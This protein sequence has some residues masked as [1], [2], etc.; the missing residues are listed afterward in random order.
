MALYKVVLIGQS[1]VG[2]SSTF[3]RFKTG[4][5]E[6]DLTSTIGLD[7]EI[8]KVSFLIDEKDPSSEKTIEI[9]LWD[10]AGLERAGRMTNNYYKNSHAIILMYDVGDLASL[11]HLRSWFE[12]ANMYAPM[13]GDH[14]Q[15]TLY[16]V[17]GNKCDLSSG[18]I[19]VSKD[20]AMTY[21]NEFLPN[22][23]D[24]YNFRISTK[25]GKG[26]DDMFCQIARTLSAIAPAQRND[27]V[28][29]DKEPGNEKGCPC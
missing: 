4:H 3:V 27:T 16:F 2:K 29:F 24:H 14:G 5:F 22:L 26:F 1:Y 21:I 17:V 15:K 28:K 8:R 12:D 20:R 11:G 7:A 13:V 19:E 9:Q 23:P 25:N 18:T 6:E 10:T